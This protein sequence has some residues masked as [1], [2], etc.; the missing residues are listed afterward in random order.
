LKLPLKTNR[1]PKLPILRIAILGIDYARENELLNEVAFSIT[2]L[3]IV[4][5]P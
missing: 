1:I 5:E 3:P 2:F 4:K